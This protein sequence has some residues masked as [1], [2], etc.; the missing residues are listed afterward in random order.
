MSKLVGTSIRLN[1]TENTFKTPNFKSIPWIGYEFGSESKQQYLPDRH[2]EGEWPKLRPGDQ[3]ELMVSGDNGTFRYVQPLPADAPR[4]MV[5]VPPDRAESLK[6]RYG[7]YKM[8]NRRRA[9]SK[10]KMSNIRQTVKDI[11]DT[12]ERVEDIST[13]WEIEARKIVDAHQKAFIE[14]SKECKSL[15]SMFNQVKDLGVAPEIVESIE[16]DY[17]AACNR[18]DNN[19]GGVSAVL[20]MTE[21]MLA[22]ESVKE[23][24]EFAIENWNMFQSMGDIARKS[25]PLLGY[26]AK[27]D[28]NPKILSAFEDA[29]N[30]FVNPDLNVGA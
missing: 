2:F 6:E 17:S 11:L 7:E 21:W 19:D 20:E 13:F 12:K 14:D 3:V 16:K 27:A 23:D 25:V 9:I 18:R 10:R 15:E 5:V 4:A 26:L 22:N 29:I 30:N 28:D 1:L 24:L 8:K